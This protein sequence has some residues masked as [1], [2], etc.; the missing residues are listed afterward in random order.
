MKLS[1]KTMTATIVLILM[2]TISSLSIMATVSAQPV[3]EN[4]SYIYICTTPKIGVNQQMF[5]VYWTQDMPPDVG[6]TIAGTRA[7]WSGVTVEVTA[8]DGTK[9][10]LDMGDSDPVGGGYIL[11]TP[12]QVGEYTV[13]AFFPGTWKNGTAFHRYYTPAQSFPSTFTVQADPI[14]GWTEVPPTTDYWMRPIAGP[15]HWNEITGNWLGSYAQKYPIGAFGGTTNNYGYGAAPAS[16]HI[17][18]TRSHFPTGSI[19]D[20]RFGNEVYTLNHYQDVDFDI[21][22]IVDGII[23]FRPQYTAHWGSGNAIEPAGWAGWDLYTGEELFFYPDDM[24]PAFGQIYLYNSPNQHGTFSYLWRTGGVELPETVTRQ[25]QGAPEETVTLTTLPG[26]QTWEMIDA[27]TL[28]RVAYVA[29]ITTSGTT[30][31]GKDGS[32]LIYRTANLGTG[33]NPNHYLQVYNMSDIRTMLAGDIATGT[34]YWQWRPQWGGHSNYQ[35]RWREHV[36]AFHDFN[37]QNNFVNVSINMQGPRN[38]R[39][40]QTATIRAVREGEY[41]IVGTQG[42]NDDQ[43]IAPAWFKAVSLE[44]GNE[45]NVLWETTFNPPYAEEWGGGFAS[46]MQYHDVYP[47]EEVVVFQ[48]RIHLIY[49]AFDLRT[50]AQLW[51][52]QDPLQWGYYALRG[53]YYNGMFIAH[54]QYGGIVT[55]LDIRTGDII[56]QYTA[57]P[58]GSE[59][60]YGNDVLN[61]LLFADG[62]AYG[63]AGE[64]S[65]STPLWRG[66]NLRCFDLETGEE[67]WNFLFWG[68][69]SNKLKTADGIL[70]GMNWYDGQV[71]AFGRGP[72]ATTVT[73][74]DIAVPLGTPVMLKGTVTDQTP[75]GRRNI[76]GQLQFSLKG[77]PAVSDEDMGAWMEY[78]FM[79]MEYPMDATGVTVDLWAVDPNGNFQDIGQTTSD[80]NGAF[81]LSWVPPVPGEYYVTASFLGSESYGGSSASTYFIVSEAPSAA[82]PI[83]PEPVTPTPTEPT[84]TEP[85]PT[86]PTPTEP[87]PTEPTPTEP[88]LPAET[89]F[90]TT[91][92]AIIAVIVVASIIGIASF[93]ALRKRK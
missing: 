12:T 1:R 77:T 78:L 70:V 52:F 72:S 48:D 23:H 50:G 44:Q 33:A 19:A 91:E 80:L 47:E 81:G 63:T 67:L 66:E 35:Y 5:M 75:T 34:A 29:N 27:Y 14:P 16:A 93:W 18:W 61:Q 64:H 40:N 84:P 46:G 42:L 41:L 25:P 88:T 65:A 92:V 85:T 7:Y 15:T 36:D 76:N 8:P 59:S 79:G 2:L 24:P 38:S 37:D 90:I 13:Q 71:Y 82:T 39:Q 6:E 73:A 58:V 20:Q 68:T 83:E 10:T 11:Y 56:W 9:Q 60:P 69:G 3:Q 28:N 32:Y 54:T 87:T 22:A 21:E 30:V 43:G 74:P 26:T 49:I 4:T 86:E 17:L 62:K 89:S 55:A 53:D 31:Y 45:G 57:H 51:E